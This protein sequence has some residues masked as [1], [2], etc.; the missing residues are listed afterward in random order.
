MPEAS[1][2][3]AKEAVKL[4]DVVAADLP[5]LYQYQLDP[6]S[7]R[8]AAVYPRSAEVFELRWADILGDPRSIAKAIVADGGVVGSIGCFKMEGLDA[9]GYWIAREYWGRGIATRALALLLEEVTIRPLHAQVARHNA[10][11]MRVLERCGFVVTGYR[12]AP[13]D[14]RYA[15]C[16]V[17]DLMLT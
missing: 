14:A 6:E 12:E 2:R 9:V 11:S 3:V 10:A 13:G 7:N 5:T 4:R 1:P 17:A 15:A 16:E 8:M